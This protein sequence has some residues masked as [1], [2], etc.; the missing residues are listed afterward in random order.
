MRGVTPR[1]F[2]AERSAVIEWSG[3]V[4]RARYMSA[5]SAAACSPSMGA[6]GAKKA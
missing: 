4:P 1:S 3:C 2:W 5:M 6:S